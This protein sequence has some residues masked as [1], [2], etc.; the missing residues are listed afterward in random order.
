[1]PISTSRFDS[2]EVVVVVV[3]V[4]VSHS[5]RDLKTVTRRWREEEGNQLSASVE[6]D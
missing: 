2:S 1:M 5:D 4:V 6:S 3:V